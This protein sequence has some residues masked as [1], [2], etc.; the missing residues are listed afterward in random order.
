MNRENNSLILVVDD[1]HFVLKSIPMLLQDCGF[2]IYA[3]ENAKDAMTALQ[4]NEIEVVLTDI[5][6]PEISGLEL[7]EEIQNIYPEMPVILMTAY[8]ELDVAVEA[9]KKGAFD[10]IMK[11]L[12][13]EILVHSVKKAVNYN[14]FRQLEKRYKCMLE[15]T[16]RIKT[17]ELNKKFISKM[18]EELRIPMILILDMLNSAFNKELTGAQKECI[19]LIKQTVY[20]AL[21]MFDDKSL[22][23]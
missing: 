15:D 12:N 3:C 4:N 11:P 1:N 20:A 7:L 14:R 5:K 22:A 17:Q 13:E 18:N 6:M 9:I 19:E 21:D 23:I 16:V 8:A 10:F 2:S